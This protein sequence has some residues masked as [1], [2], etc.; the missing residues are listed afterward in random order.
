VNQ[1]NTWFQPAGY[2]EFELT[3]VSRWRIVPGMRVDYAANTGETDVSPRL[4]SRVDVVEGFPRTTLKGGI[5]MF[6]QPPQFQES[7]PPLGTLGL[8]SN[9]AI[10]YGLGVE[11]EITRQFEASLEG[12]Y[13]QLDD[14]VFSGNSASG[15]LV[16]YANS[17][18]GSVVGGELLLRY[19]PD[20]HF[21]GWLAYTLSRSVRRRTPDA[22]TVPVFWDQTHIL[23][24][25]GS[26][27]L[28]HGW[29]FGARSR[30]RLVSG[31]LADPNV[32]NFADE[33][34]DPLRINAL[35]HAA[36]GSYTPI[37]FGGDNSERLPVYHTLDVRVDKVIQFALWKLSIYLDIQNVYNNQN[38]EA[39]SYDYRFSTRQYVTGIPI[40]PSFG[41]R[42]EF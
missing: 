1:Q 7:I 40:L 9:R 21:F 20:E 28:G 13:K 12:F 26:Y 17:G 11:Q 25:L 4:N 3:P 35:Y 42:G 22:E 33:A 41:L 27:R 23:T 39:I 10:H 24:M 30:F 38:V 6:H 8:S 18:D 19:K 14:L 31:N 5:G 36:S 29:E 37:R 32:C 2:L 15:A 34:C 16:E